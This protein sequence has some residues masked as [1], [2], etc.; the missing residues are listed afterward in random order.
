[1]KKFF[2]K[3]INENIY[4]EFNSYIIEGGFPKAIEFDDL[5]S[6]LLYTRE[7]ISEIFNKDVRTRNRISNKALFERVQ[8]YIINNYASPFSLKNSMIL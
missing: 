2:N 1:M 8:L 6:K 5:R 3:K 4:E 7:I